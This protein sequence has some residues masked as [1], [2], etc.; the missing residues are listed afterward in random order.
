M[1]GR[2]VLSDDLPDLLINWY[3][4]NKRDLPWRMDRDPY[5]VWLSEIMLQQTRVEAVK[6]YYQRFLAALPKISDLAACPDDILN[7]LWE[8]LG[9]YSRARNLKKAAGVIIEQYGGQFPNTYRDVLSLPG[10]GEYTAGAVMSICFDEPIPAVDGNVLRVISRLTGSRRN[11]MDPKVKSEIRDS[12][13]EI[14]PRVHSGLFTQSLMELGATVCLPNGIPKCSSCPLAARCEALR[15]GSWMDI[16]VRSPKKPRKKEQ[17][18]VFLLK[19]ELGTAVRRRPNKGLLAGLWELPNTPGTLT[20]QQALDQVRM[21]GL[22]PVDLE[23]EIHKTHIFTHIE[24]EMVGYLIRC[25]GNSDL[26]LWASDERLKNDLSLPT[27][28]RQFLEF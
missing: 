14:Y 24:W 19:S 9:Y 6:P 17:K 5:H 16:P 11:I 12:L 4:Q 18:T 2:I 1:T 23:N 27:A 3:Q 20:P 7:K 25:K 26:L 13:L 21:W 28:F 22:Y 15:D 10:I 8:G